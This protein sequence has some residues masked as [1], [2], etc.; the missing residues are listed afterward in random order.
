MPLGAG[1]WGLCWRRCQSG[2]EGMPWDKW[3]QGQP[4]TTAATTCF[5]H[6]HLYREILGP[7]PLFW[8]HSTR[9]LNSHLSLGMSQTAFMFFIHSTHGIELASGLGS[10]C[11]LHH[12]CRSDMYH[13]CASEWVPVCSHSLLLSFWKY[14]YCGRL[15]IKVQDGSCQPSQKSSLSSL[16]KQ[17]I[18]S[19]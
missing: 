1:I 16:H 14:T 13:I 17:L 5:V 3:K 7:Q 15:S 18:L 6:R 10:L 9:F 2:R 19:F 11:S 4:Q 12:W 8:I